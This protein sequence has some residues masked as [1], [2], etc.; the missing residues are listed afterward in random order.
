MSGT[1]LRRRMRALFRF[2]AAAVAAGTALAA[3][4]VVLVKQVDR[5][6]FEGGETAE[7]KTLEL[8]PLAARSVVYARDGTILAKWHEEEN[9]APVTLDRVPPHVIRAVLDAEDDR[10]F[11]HGAL[12]PRALTRA[13]VVNVESGGIEEG[14]STITQQLVKI[15]LLNQEQSADRKIK[16]AALAIRLEEEMTKEQILERYI[17]AVYLGNHAY[18]FGAAAETYFGTTIE[19][20]SLGQG[21]LLAGMIRDPVGSD[22]WTN[23]DQARDRRNKVVDRMRELNHVSFEEAERVKGEPLPSRP[24]PEPAKG[25]DYFVEYVKQ[26]LLRDPRLGAT[27]ADRFNALFKGGLSIHTT[28]DP[29]YQ[30]MAE[31]AVNRILPDTDGQFLAA[32]ASVEPGTGAIRAMVGGPGF[33]KSKFNLAADG[34]GR[35]PGS[36]FKPFTLMAAFE[37]GF[38]PDDSINGASPC[39]VDNPGGPVW[40]PGNVEGS[41]GGTLSL[42]DAT[43]QSVNCAYARLVKMVGPE[44]VVDVARRMGITTPI[45]PH[46]AVTLGSELVTPLDMASA[47]GT[48]A[49]DGVRHPPFGVDRIVDATGKEI[50]RNG[51]PGERVVSHQHARMATGVLTQGVQRGTGRAAAIPPWT[52]AGKT[53]TTDNNTN[54][55]FVGYTPVL[56]TA[57]WMGSPTGDVPMKSVGGITVFGGTYPARIWN[58]FMGPALANVPPVGF[59]PPDAPPPPGQFRGAPGEGPDPR[60]PAPAQ[61]VTR[62]QVTTRPAPGG[63]PAP[64]RAPAPPPAAEPEPEPEPEPAP[65][66]APRPREY[67]IVY[68]PYYP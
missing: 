56:S 25:S 57:V 18:G 12:D 66:P 33:D 50:L 35:Q 13:L 32:L 16:E 64:R 31:D 10:F 17:N 47:Y 24:P 41:A 7:N 62:R 2:V 53:G 67:I 34:T 37:Q 1:I 4:T 15:T 9:R 60:Q 46:L 3:G 58:A 52:A 28:L 51:G 42:T 39:P 19:N 61:V 30:R 22:P 59:P 36:A 45:Q 63:A 49:A 27:E 40:S 23:P 65:P 6:L 8:R 54:A 44:K 29:S 55:W 68:E 43:V 26:Q 5:L 11:E 14:G 48:L 38:S 21:I 20:L